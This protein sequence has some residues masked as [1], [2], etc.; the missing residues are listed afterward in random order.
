M[1]LNSNQ[2]PLEGHV[3]PEVLAQLISGVGACLTNTTV[4]DGGISLKDTG[5]FTDATYNTRW[6]WETLLDDVGLLDYGEVTNIDNWRSPSWWMTLRGVVER[7]RYLEIQAGMERG[8]GDAVYTGPEDISTGTT[9]RDETWTIESGAAT[10]IDVGSTFPAWTGYS[11]NCFII[12]GTPATYFPYILKTGTT[13]HAVFIKS[14]EFPVDW[15]TDYKQAIDIVSGEPPAYVLGV[16]R[17]Y[18]P[19]KSAHNGKLIIRVE[20]GREDTRSGY[21]GELLNGADISWKDG[22]FSGVDE[23]ATPTLSDME[24]DLSFAGSSFPSLGDDAND[25]LEIM[26]SPDGSSDFS[27]NFTSDLPVSLPSDGYEPDDGPGTS[28]I[29]GGQFWATLKQINAQFDLNSAY[30]YSAT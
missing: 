22:D 27:S 4:S 28:V 8:G 21:L 16:A 5:Y 18:P 6:T 11:F 14:K 20:L 1:K 19:P 30:T 2:D 17:T 3:L 10:D 29:V 13:D 25:W 7:L 26:A 23:S 24:L 15:D 9:D 12:S